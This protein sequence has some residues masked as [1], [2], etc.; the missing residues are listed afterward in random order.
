MKC[1][2]CNHD[3]EEGFI[4]NPSQPLAFYESKQIPEMFSFCLPEGAKELEETHS[5]YNGYKAN[6][7]YCYNCDIVISKVRK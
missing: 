5:V 4:H 2:F 7:L 1:P 3:L 6:A